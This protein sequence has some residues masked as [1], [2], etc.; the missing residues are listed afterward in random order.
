[1][2]GYALRVQSH[3][4]KGRSPILKD[5]AESMHWQMWPGAFRYDAARPCARRRTDCGEN[6]ENSADAPDLH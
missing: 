2:R 1:M 5:I 6:S 3:V 4:P